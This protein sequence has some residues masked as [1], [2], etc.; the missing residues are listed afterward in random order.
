MASIA[1]QIK[2]GPVFIQQLPNEVIGLMIEAA[3]RTLQGVGVPETDIPEKGRITMV[4]RR[5]C[6]D[7]ERAKVFEKYL[8]Q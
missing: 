7:S 2:T 4:V 5:L 6:R 3:N 8:R 1:V